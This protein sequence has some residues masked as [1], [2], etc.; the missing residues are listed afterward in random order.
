MIAHCSQFATDG[1]A[2]LPVQLAACRFANVCSTWT[3]DALILP[4]GFQSGS[5]PTHRLLR[6]P[7]YLTAS[8]AGTGRLAPHGVHLRSHRGWAW[9]T[10]PAAGSERW[11]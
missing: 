10:L 8:T 1:E 11:P 7:F 9:R 5:K 2:H 4:D 3:Q 6:W